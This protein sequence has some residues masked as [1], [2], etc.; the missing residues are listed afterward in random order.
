MILVDA[1]CYIVGLPK[2]G[3]LPAACYL[4]PATHHSLPACNYLL[5]I[6][7]CPLP[8]THYLPPTTYYSLPTTTDYSLSITYCL[9]PTTYYL[10]PT[11]YYLL[12]TT[13]L[14]H[15]TRRAIPQDDFRAVRVLPP[16]RCSYSPL[17]Q[18]NCFLRA[19]LSSCPMPS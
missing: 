7:Y 2:L 4:L 6:A 17:D 8:T 11:T 13:T 16:Q 15:H 1:D 19:G 5:P 9:L 3:V 14:L 18:S 12:P 10:L